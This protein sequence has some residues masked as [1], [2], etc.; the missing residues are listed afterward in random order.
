MRTMPRAQAVPLSRKEFVI[1]GVL[2][3]LL[4]CIPIAICTFI[5]SWTH[6]QIQ[7]WVLLLI[8]VVAGCLIF[9][10]GRPLPIRRQDLL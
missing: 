8:I 5:G 3:P 2:A 9:H 7:V 10:I 1:D 4:F 6:R